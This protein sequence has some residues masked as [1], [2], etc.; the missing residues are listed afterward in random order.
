MSDKARKG[1]PPLG[2][3]A[4]TAS[5]K[6]FYCGF[7]VAIAALIREYDQPSMALGIMQSNGVR[8]ADLRQA[9]VDAFDLRPIVKA[10]RRKIRQG[11]AVTGQT[12]F[13]KFDGGG[14]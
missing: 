5:D 11:E 3:A 9:K 4:M 12:R 1:K 8:L 14:R 7:A 2:Q 6:E 13:P 10:S